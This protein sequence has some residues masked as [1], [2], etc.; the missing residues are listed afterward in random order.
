MAARRATFGTVSFYTMTLHGYSADRLP[1]S[2]VNRP[3]CDN[4][5]SAPKSLAA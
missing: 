2:C 5:I 1:A 3:L 4:S